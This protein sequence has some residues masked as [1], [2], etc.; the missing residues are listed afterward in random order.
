MDDF[1]LTD[2]VEHSTIYVSALSHKMYRSSGGQGL[3]GSNG[4]FVCMQDAKSPDAGFEILAK[5]ATIEA[6]ELIFSALVSS[7]RAKHA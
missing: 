3:G 2:T 5:A 6:A 1:F 7:L 4:F